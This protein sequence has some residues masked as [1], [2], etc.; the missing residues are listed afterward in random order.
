MI[1]TSR[2]ARIL[3]GLYEKSPHDEDFNA[4]HESRKDKNKYPH[5]WVCE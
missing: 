1:V 4:L 2:G 3:C 5:N